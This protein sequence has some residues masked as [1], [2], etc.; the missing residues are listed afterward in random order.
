MI[1]FFSKAWT[2]NTLTAMLPFPHENPAHSSFP[3]TA[4]IFFSNADKLI[5]QTIEE[6]RNGAVLS[7]ALIHDTLVYS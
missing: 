3:D 4:G 5:K 7:P 6:H 1:F 2:D